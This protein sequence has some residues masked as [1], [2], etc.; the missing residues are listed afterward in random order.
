MKTKQSN[1]ANQQDLKRVGECLYRSQNSNIY[2][3]ILKRGGKQIKRSLRTTDG[4]LAR[5]RLKDLNEQASSLAKG[6]DAKATFEMISERWLNM[7]TTSLKASSAN[8]LRGVTKS[9]SKTFGTLQVRKITKAMLEDWAAVRSKEVAAQTYNFERNS[10]V[11]LLDYAQR[12]GLILENPARVLKRLKMR[13]SKPDIPT[14]EEFATLLSEMKK[15]R[16][17]AKDGVELCELLAYSGCRLGEGI[18]ITW[19]DINFRKKQFTVTGGETGTKNHEA[20]TVPLFPALEAFLKRLLE[21]M[22]APPNKKATVAKIASAK[23][24]MMHACKNADLPHFTHHHLRHFF[25]SNAIEAGIDFKAI[26]GWLGHKDGGLLVAKTYG[27]LRD[28]HSA[29]MAK[30]MTFGA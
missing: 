22:P 29:E 16:E 1:G 2:Y 13:Q 18:S 21:E 27:H 11:R 15:L 7:A 24:A 25:C 28:E 17:G 9:L 10:M 20:R 5:R 8:R 23:K 14:K 4:A 3:A 30:R 6:G 19:G 26:A 12:E